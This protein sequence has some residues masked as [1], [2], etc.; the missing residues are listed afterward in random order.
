MRIPQP[1]GLLSRGRQVE[2]APSFFIYRA[3][4]NNRVGVIILPVGRCFAASRNTLFSRSGRSQTRV[5][6]GYN[7]ESGAGRVRVGWH[8]AT[9]RVAI[10]RPTR[11]NKKRMPNGDPRPHSGIRFIPSNKMFTAYYSLS[12]PMVLLPHRPRCTF[13]QAILSA[14]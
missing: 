6:C 2:V 7:C 10:L 12:P 5:G 4:K 1:L 3:M 13:S 8:K 14:V 9:S 11:A